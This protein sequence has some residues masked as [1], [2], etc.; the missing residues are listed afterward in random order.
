MNK[1][2][3]VFL[4]T[5]RWS[6]WPLLVIVVAFMV[7]GYAMTGQ[8]GCD[9]L[10]NEEAALKLHRSLHWLLIALLVAHCV[11]AVYLALVRWGWIKQRN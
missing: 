6:S 3:L 8:F 1:L 5:V 10:M 11:P 2:N 9:Q 4:K 7:S